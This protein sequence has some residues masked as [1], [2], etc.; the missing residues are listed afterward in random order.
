MEEKKTSRIALLVLSFGIMA[1]IVPYFYDRSLWIEEAMLASSIINRNLSNMLAFPLDMG[2]RAPAGYLYIVKLLTIIFNPSKLVLRIWS[3]ISFAACLYLLKNICERVLDVRRW[4]IYTA[5]VA[6]IPIYIYYGNDLK[7]YMSDCFFVLLAIYLFA[8]YE[9]RKLDLN[10]LL[11]FNS[12]II[13]FSYAAVFFVAAGMLL[14]LGEDCI[15]LVKKENDLLRLIRKTWKYLFVLLSF[16]LNYLLW[17]SY[18]HNNSGI[19]EKR[20]TLKFPLIPRT[21]EALHTM[22]DMLKEIF[23][24]LREM[25]LILPLVMILLALL[26]LVMIIKERSLKTTDKQI[27]LGIFILLLA[28]CRGYYPVA[29]RFMLFIPILL[30]LFNIPLMEAVIDYCMEKE[31]V[32]LK[33]ALILFAFFTAFQYGKGVLPSYTA[34]GVYLPGSEVKPG[35]RYLKANLQEGD[36]VYIR[37]FAIPSYLY[38]TGYGQGDVNLM[39]QTPKIIGNCILG[40]ETYDYSRLQSEEQMIL[41]DAIAEDLALIEQYPSVYI[42]SSHENAQIQPDVQLLLEGLWKSGKV[43]LISDANETC[44]YHYYKTENAVQ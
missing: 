40:Q 8:L 22:I 31:G 42:F 5:F 33:A 43:D 30:L 39:A 17:L 12:I 2:Q 18:R 25:S 13:W 23:Y 29:T 10:R 19:P 26:R 34:K 36:M 3:L 27:C 28:S 21:I 32:L 24:P 20:E 16:I 41:Y 44:L 35:I 7:P 1:H 38:E 4:C 37:N 11:L 14:L 15:K 6:I 9:K